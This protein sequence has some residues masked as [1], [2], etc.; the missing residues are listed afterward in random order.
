[1]IT[2]ENTLVD[3]VA[4]LSVTCT[5]NENGLPV[6]F[7]GVPVI[8]PV[9][10]F[11]VAHAG[12]VPPVIAQFVYGG[13]P[14]VAAKV[15]LYMLLTV[16][17][18]SGDSV[19]MDSGGGATVKLNT[20]VEVTALLSVT[21]TVNE[22]GLPVMFGGVPVIW[23]VMAFR[24]AHAGNVPPV[25][26]QFVY[27]GTPPV[28]V[29]VWLYMVLTVAPGSGDVVV[30]DSGG[31]TTVSV[32]TLVAVTIALSVTCTV[33]EN[34][35]PVV[36]GGVP[37]IW[38]VMAFRV[39][40]AGNVPAVIA[41]FVYGGVPPV[42]AKVWL[43]MLLTVPCGSGEVVVIES[44]LPGLVTSQLTVYVAGL[45]VAL[46]VTVSVPV[47]MPA[48]AFEQPSVSVC[49]LLPTGI[50]NG[51]AEPF[52]VI[53]GPPVV[54]YAEMIRLSVPVLEMT[55]LDVVGVPASV[56]MLIIEPGLGFEA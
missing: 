4:L 37:V 55:T 15:W 27:G 5:V 26:A 40:H 35:L 7:G 29:K 53:C 13:T 45:P 16:A 9:I 10:A 42:A 52:T 54:E 33:N 32:N 30:I 23:P 56:D 43:Y 48:V 49:V 47:N 18:G 21:C 38:P 24:V 8:W 50:V 22:N 46:C 6:V 11:R 2:S 12:N 14:P 3:V 44:G 34:G 17:P 36:F 31:A 1:M 25:I 28:A 39:A 51:G 19:V 41:Q 20:F